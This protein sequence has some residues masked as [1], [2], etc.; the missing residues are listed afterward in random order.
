MR[1]ANIGYGRRM[2]DSGLSLL[3]VTLILIGYIV[4]CAIVIVPLWRI[5]QRAGLSPVLSFLVAI[6][7]AGPLVVLLL[8]AFTEWPALELKRRGSGQGAD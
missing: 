6:P 1:D 2:S 7:L 4:V 3:T 8:L 5:H